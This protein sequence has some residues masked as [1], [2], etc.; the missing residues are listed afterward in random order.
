MKKFV[1]AISVM[2]FPLLLAAQCFETSLRFDENFAA[3]QKIESSRP[4]EYSDRDTNAL[5]IFIKMNEA[6]LAAMK[7]VE[8]EA[9]YIMVY[10]YCSAIDG[11]EW[12]NTK[13]AEPIGGMIATLEKQSREFYLLR[14]TSEYYLAA[15]D[16]AYG[17]ID[18]IANEYDSAANDL[19]TVPY[20]KKQ[21]SDYTPI[22][23]YWISEFFYRWFGSFKIKA[24]E[25][26]L[27]VAKLKAT[28]FKPLVALADHL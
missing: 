27:V 17:Q 28:N 16:F 4:E 9:E 19:M 12:Q 15:V 18:R 6:A 20:L 1:L 3:Y 23:A 11:R 26:D 2:A 25:T 7:S 21:F 14:F 24:S 5:S 22:E 10:A 13:Y 8:N